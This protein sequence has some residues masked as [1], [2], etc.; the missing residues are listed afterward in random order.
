MYLRSLFL[1]ELGKNSF[2]CHKSVQM[3]AQRNLPEFN[4]RC[5]RKNMTSA[6]SR[7]HCIALARLP[8]LKWRCGWLPWRNKAT[9]SACSWI[10]RVWKS[11]SELCTSVLGL[12]VQLQAWT[13]LPGT[14]LDPDG[15]IH[16]T[17]FFE[18]G[19]S[20]TRL[21]NPAVH[22]VQQQILYLLLNS[23]NE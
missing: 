9:H 3:T 21:E 6:L 14:L 23:M 11:K 15:R 1:L 4:Y 18:T 2:H 8:W 17:I 19:T 5:C 7:Q 22:D 16:L 12:D 10:T 20:S 13:V